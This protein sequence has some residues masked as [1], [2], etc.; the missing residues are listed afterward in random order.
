[1]ETWREAGRSLNFYLRPQTFPL[2]V[3][4]VER[5]EQIPEQ[6]RRPMRDLGKRLA[7]CQGAAI[8]RKYGWTVA[9]AGVDSGCAIADLNYGWTEDV[10]LDKVIAFATRM[11]YA[12]DEDAARA[13]MAAVPRLAP[14]RCHAAVYSPL[15][16]TSVEP[17]VILIY[18]NPAQLM[19]LI[20]GATQKEGKPITCSFLGRMASCTEGVL[21][22]YT[23][24]LPKIV[25]P[26]NGDR[27]WATAQDD[28][29]AFVIPAAQLEDMIDGLS[30]THQRGIRYPVPAFVDFQPMVGLKIP[31]SDIF[32]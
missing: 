28:E 3:K 15:E 5:E 24:Q 20:H 1:M 11:N 21:A 14:G 9:V 17:D 32:K 4:L 25:V 16:K 6:A 26:G 12:R 7:P 19:R 18:C 30:Q 2:A 10:D 22:S 31:L 29:M 27:V 13:T 23:Q 8:A